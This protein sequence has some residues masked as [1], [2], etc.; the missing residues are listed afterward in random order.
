MLPAAVAAALLVGAPYADSDATQNP[1]ASSTATK[2][3][4]VQ[5]THPGGMGTTRG[6]TVLAGSEILFVGL[7]AGIVVAARRSSRRATA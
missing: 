3:S 5:A 4:A 2:H 7:G 6:I 1:Q